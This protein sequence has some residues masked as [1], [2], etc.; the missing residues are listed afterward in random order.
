MTKEEALKHM[1]ADAFA[2]LQLKLEKAS[3]SKDG[4]SATYTYEGN[5]LQATFAIDVSESALRDL[6]K[7]KVSVTKNTLS[8]A[9]GECLEEAIADRIFQTKG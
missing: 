4:V 6:T 3:L 9:I 7:S 5:G 1:P 8:D 2:T